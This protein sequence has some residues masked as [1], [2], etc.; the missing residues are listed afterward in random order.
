MGVQVAADL[1]ERDQLGQLAG[2]GR[3]DL[4]AAL[5]QLGLDVGQAEQLVDAGLVGEAVD[6]GL[7]PLL[8]LVSVTPCSETERPR[9]SAR[10]RS[11][12]LCSAEPVKCWSRLPNVSS[13][14]DPEVHLEARVGQ[15]AG[16]RLARRAGLR[17]Q[18]VL[19]ER[20]AERGRVVAGRDEVDVLAGLGPAP[21]RARHLDPA[22]G[23]QGLHRRRQLLGDRQDLGEQPALGLVSPASGSVSS[24]ASTF[25]STLAPEPLD[26]ADLLLLGGLAQPLEV[27]DAELVVEAPRGLR[28]EPGDAGH[29]HERG[30]GT[31][32]SAC[33]PRG[34]RPSRSASR[35]S[36]PASC[37]SPAARSAGRPGRAARA[38]R[39]CPAIVRAAS[40]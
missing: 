38:R 15:H 13:G 28:A 8:R 12:T 10:S 5:A 19:G 18:L 4:A 9:A 21:G 37:R 22:R 31:S 2:L 16:P 33:R 20:L 39:G 25:S 40:L 36:R 14:G 35:P 17:H 1:L 34:S 3:L 27:R 30:A 24:A 6:L 23:G 26:V 7:L 11:W 32:P 29:V